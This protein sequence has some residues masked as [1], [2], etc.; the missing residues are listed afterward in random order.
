MATK[1]TTRVSVTLASV[2][3]S[4][5]VGCQKNSYQTCVDFQTEA[6]TRE[7]KTFTSPN[8]ISLQKLIDSRVSEYCRGV[9]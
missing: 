6:A 7:Y 8:N 1:S 4:L 3:L 5:L 2:L 9:K